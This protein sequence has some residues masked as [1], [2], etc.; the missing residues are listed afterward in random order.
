MKQINSEI[1]LLQNNHMIVEIKICDKYNPFYKNN[2][3]S[4]FIYITKIFTLRYRK[5]Y[6][7]INY[8]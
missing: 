5:Y 4:F 2:Q 6:I 8:R 3:L 1:T 7:N